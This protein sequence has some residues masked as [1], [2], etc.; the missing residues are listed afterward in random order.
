MPLLS[1]RLF[2]GLQRNGSDAFGGADAVGPCAFVKVIGRL[3]KPTQD[4]EMSVRRGAALM[5]KAAK[6]LSAR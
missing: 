4:D 1:W 3:G 5:E 6:G 2:E